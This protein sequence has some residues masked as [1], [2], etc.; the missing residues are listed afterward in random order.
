MYQ[1]DGVHMLLG[2][3]KDFDQARR[4]RPDLPRNSA[5]PKRALIGD[6]RNDEN[7]IVSQLQ[8]LFLRFHNAV[9]DTAAGG[10]FKKAQ[11]IV[12]WHYQWIVLYDFL[13]RVVGKDTH[14]TVIGKPGEGC[15][16]LR[17]YHAGGR[18]AYIPVEFSVA[19][20]RFGHSMVRPS[21]SLNR[22][23]VKATP[24][25]QKFN[26]RD[27]KF[28][29]IPIFSLLNTEL[30]NLNGFRE[31]PGFWAIDWA[32]FFDGVKADGAV[33][34]GAVLP[35][36]SYK[37]DTV[38]VD[39]LT[40]LPDH[41]NEIPMRRAL[42]S[43]NLLRGWRLELPSGQSVAHRMGF[44]ALTDAQL[45]DH[46]DAERKAKRAAVLQGN[47]MFK[48]SA[49]LWFYILREAELVGKSK[50]LGPV[51]GTIVAEVLAGLIKEDRHSFLS[52]WPTW[53][54]TLPAK[55]NGLF[56]MADLVDFT[57]QHS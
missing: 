39:P 49:P 45:F 43:L 57:N 11:D 40:S 38:L 50:H 42:A 44:D 28:E 46:E 15:K 23:V 4:K 55:T 24:D 19:A 3:D 22:I 48:D 10:D 1:D 6:K 13:P 34:P 17:F 26:G 21:Y 54:P 7:V 35:Q 29:R 53:R 8:T 25:T 27:A 14:K 41:Q 30:A 9:L 56:T 36:P 52:V 31:L 33:P 5:T 47:P 16:D 2:P 32:F 18:Y 51:G 37:L 20:Y 12:R